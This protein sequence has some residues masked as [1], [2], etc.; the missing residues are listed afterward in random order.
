MQRLWLRNT[1][2]ETV[3]QRKFYYFNYSKKSKAVVGHTKKT[4]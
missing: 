2:E 1:G 3:N 4:G